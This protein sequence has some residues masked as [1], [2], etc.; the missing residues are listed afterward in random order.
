MIVKSAAI[1]LKNNKLLA[2]KK[3]KHDSHYIL[4]GG[5]IEHGETKEQA[6]IRE[7]AEELNITVNFGNLTFYKTIEAIA[8]YEN[9]PL[10]SHIYFVDY[11][12]EI[13]VANEI[14]EFSWLDINDVN[15]DELTSTLKAVIKSLL[16]ED[17]YV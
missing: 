17:S 12:G 15:S 7:L 3:K 11:N 10:I 14:S 6:L 4:P 16:A 2:V 13:A 1:I 5:K 8:K 9:V